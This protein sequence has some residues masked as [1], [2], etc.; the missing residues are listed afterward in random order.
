MVVYFI[1]ERR[2]AFITFWILGC[3]RKVSM[4]VDVPLL[5]SSFLLG[6]VLAIGPVVIFLKFRV[7]LEQHEGLC[8]IELDFLE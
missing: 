6:N 5:S 2:I 3:D 7:L 1:L 4:N 8:V